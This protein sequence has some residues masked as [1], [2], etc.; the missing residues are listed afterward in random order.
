[1]ELYMA[2]LKRKDP[3]EIGHEIACGRREARA[4]WVSISIARPQVLQ[5]EAYYGVEARGVPC[6][7]W[8][9]TSCYLL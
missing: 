8:C 7:D 9:R 3:E 6:G 1:M 2:R 5:G 4:Q